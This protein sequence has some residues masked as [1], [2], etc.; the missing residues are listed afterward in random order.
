MLVIQIV[1]VVAVVAVEVVEG[2]VEVFTF[3]IGIVVVMVG[4]WDRFISW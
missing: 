2:A 4:H 3:V 1:I